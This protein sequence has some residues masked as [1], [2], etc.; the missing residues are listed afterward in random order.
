MRA[1]RL[2]RPPLWIVV[3]VA[4]CLPAQE[5]IEEASPLV[6]EGIRLF[7]QQKVDEAIETLK[8][9]VEQNPNDAVAYNALGVIHSQKG[10]FE[11]ALGYF[12]KAIS[13]RDPYYKAIYN[14]LNLLVSNRKYDDAVSLMKDLVARHPEHADGWINLAMLVG[15]RGSIEEALGYID[16]VLGVDPQDFDALVKKGQLYLLDKRYNEAHDCFEQAKRI[17]PGYQPAVDFAKLAA[18]IIE[19]KNQGY[20]RIRQILVQNPQLAERIKEEIA[21]GAD[22]S[23]LAAQHSIDISK[24]HGGDLGF[25]KRGELIEVI[26]QVIFSLEVGQVSDIV[27]SPRGFHI[28]KREE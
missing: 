17:A 3:A 25:V 28:F 19:K 6:Q 23:K 13:L 18:D 5:S 7:Q 20:I 22:F 4:A 12:D 10:D 8:R 2:I 11:T 15:N 26:E 24:N 9:A 14:K 16:K 21:G 1:S 27:I